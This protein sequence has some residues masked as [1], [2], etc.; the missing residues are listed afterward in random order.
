MA[1]GS[2]GVSEEVEAPP[3]SLPVDDYEFPADPALRWALDDALQAACFSRYVPPPGRREGRPKGAP[4]PVA[5]PQLLPTELL[6]AVAAFVG[7]LDLASM[8]GTCRGW[9]TT[10]RQQWK[11]RGDS[12]RDVW[13]EVHGCFFEDV[14]AIDFCVPLP[15]PA[16]SV[17]RAVRHQHLALDMDLTLADDILA[18]HWRGHYLWHVWRHT[19]RPALLDSGAALFTQ[20][21]RPG[22]GALELLAFVPGG[23]RR[24]CTQFACYIAD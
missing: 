3:I 8:L 22:S 23:P 20:P 1:L 2:A 5:R 17:M 18:T 13:H 6:S 10:A 15:V 11:A 24:Q 16:A 21:S 7:G 12:L 4:R 9:E 19:V 14:G